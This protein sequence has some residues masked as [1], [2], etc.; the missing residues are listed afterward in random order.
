MANISGLAHFLYVA[1]H[2]RSIALAE[3]FDLALWSALLKRYPQRVLSIPP[4]GIRM[5]MTDPVSVSLMRGVRAVRTG[6]AP[7]ERTVRDWFETTYGIPILNQYGASEFCGVIATVGL[8]E[9]RGFDE[10]QRTSVGRA[11]HGSRLR[12]VDPATGAALPAGATGVL[13]AQVDRIGPDW[14]RTTDLARLDGDGLLYLEGRADDAINRGGFK[15]LPDMVADAIRMH[16]SVHDAAV[17]G[18]SDER[19]GQVPVAAIELRAGTHRPDAAEWRDFLRGHLLS[20][21][22]PTEIVVVESIPRNAGLKIDRMA[23]RM[24]LENRSAAG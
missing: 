15:V 19:L 4:A 10:V 11:R 7:L 16:P 14:L 2:G 13:E 3:K 12:V 5:I 8:D 23:L 9:Y 17:V 20:Y 18:M 24:L 22:I 21:Q 1:V 6:A